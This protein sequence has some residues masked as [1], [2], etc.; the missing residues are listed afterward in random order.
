MRLKIFSVLVIITIMLI[1]LTGCSN[2][3]INQEDG[4]IVHTT[5]TEEVK[6]TTESTNDTEEKESSS[7]R[8]VDT[9]DYEA[10]AKKQLAMPEKGDT[11]ATI[12][13]KG[14]GEIKVK[15]FEEAAPK[16]VENFLTHAKEGYYDGLIFHRVMN[17]FMIQGGDPL[18]TGTGGESI[19]GKGFGEELDFEL[20]PYRGALSMASTG[21]GTNGI[22]SQFYIVQGHYN[23]EHETLLKE[24]NFPEKL[25]GQYKIHGGY[26]SSLYLNYTIFGQV[27]EGMD[28]VDK[29]AKVETNPNNDKPVTDVVI[30]K[31]TVTEYK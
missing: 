6:N 18:G 17:E 12:K 5:S 23:E 24:M 14:Y 26:P 9:I 21:K 29:I 7:T 16:A 1:C 19:W 31:I 25:I 28:I 27:Y 8:V 20:V 30:E 3:G 15:F 13:V 10:A 4:N 22:G 2:E 11:V